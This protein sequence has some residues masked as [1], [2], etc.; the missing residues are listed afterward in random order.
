M[1]DAAPVD[2]AAE[3]GEDVAPL[4]LTHDLNGDLIRFGA[5]DDGGKTGHTP[6]HQLNTP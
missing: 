6:I 2:V 1:N 3:E 4:K 5:P